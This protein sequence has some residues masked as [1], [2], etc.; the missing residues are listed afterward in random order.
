MTRRKLF[1][2]AKARRTLPLVSR[3]VTDIRNKYVTVQQ[4][5][6]QLDRLSGDARAK[7]EN[8]ALQLEAQIYAHVNELQGI[9]CELKDYEKGLIDFYASRDGEVIYLCWMLGEDDIRFWH[10]LEGGFG[11]RQPISVLPESTLGEISPPA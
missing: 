2:V 10:T 8:E 6:R 11:A 4:V 1:T 3:I 5:R 7:K 9:G